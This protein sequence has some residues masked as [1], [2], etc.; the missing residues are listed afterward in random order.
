MRV[1]QASLVVARPVRRGQAE[2]GRAR[3]TGLDTALALCT[4]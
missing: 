4:N 3:R 1:D 2:A